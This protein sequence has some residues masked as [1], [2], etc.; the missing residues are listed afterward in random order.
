MLRLSDEVGQKVIIHRTASPRGGVPVDAMVPLIVT[1]PSTA[2]AGRCRIP[3]DV[4][5]PLPALVGPLDRVL[6]SNRIATGQRNPASDCARVAVGHLVIIVLV[7]GGRYQAILLL[8]R[9]HPGG[10]S[11]VE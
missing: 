9:D 5:T 6:T 7:G 10:Q 8:S 2:A 3:V 1:A 11:V 4:A